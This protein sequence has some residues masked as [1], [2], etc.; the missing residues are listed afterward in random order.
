MKNE[1]ALV[2]YKQYLIVEKGVSKNTLLGYTRDI[3][4][5]IRFLHT[6]DIVTI[7]QTSKSIVEEYIQMLSQHVSRNTVTRRMVSLRNFYIFLTREEI[8]KDNILSQ[9]DL[10]KVEEYLPTVLSEME[11]RQ[12]LD[13]IPMDNS[14]NMRNRCVLELLYATGIRVSE[15]TTLT[16]SHCHCKQQYITVIGKGNKER[17]VPLTN[18]ISTLLQKYIKLAR[19]ELL[20]NDDSPYVFVSKKGHP[21]AR[22]QVY[23]IV[24]DNANYNHI[25]KKVSP[26][27]F[28]HTFATHILEHGADLRSIQELL[29][30]SDINTTMIYTHISKTQ[31]QK[32][33]HAFHPRKNKNKF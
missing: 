26:H 18:Y 6:I 23:Q 9:F 29:G 2:E 22:Q 30:H 28:R 32:E 31:L 7:E 5:Y 11:I 15:L 3:Q 20:G 24:R 33:Y 14:M 12:I 10:P 17:F 1:V 21:M 19:N 16:L 4:D 27:S 25:A 8:I 13:T